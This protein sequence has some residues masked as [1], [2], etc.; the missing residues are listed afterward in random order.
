MPLPLEPSCPAD[1][2]TAEPL[3]AQ[4]R[5]RAPRRP[6]QLWAAT[7]AVCFCSLTVLA[8]SCLPGNAY[9]IPT[10]A[11][12]RRPVATATTYRRC[13]TAPDHAEAESTPFSSGDVD[14]NI[15]HQDEY[16]ENDDDEDGDVHPSVAWLY[17]SSTTPPPSDGSSAG[18]RKKLRRTLCVD[19]GTR[20]VGLAIGIGISPRVVPGVTNRG[21]ELEVVRQV[22]VRA[23]GEGIRDIVVGLP[24]ER[25]VYTAHPGQ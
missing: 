25:R 24:L 6:R 5:R 15:H 19:Y 23:R 18:S 10:A 3:M 8:P 21:N 12:L 1:T 9:V 11:L 14:D 7:A 2:H 16:D 4:T 13:N 20:R 22:L 17:P